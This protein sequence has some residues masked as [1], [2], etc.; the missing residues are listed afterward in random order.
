MGGFADW[1]ETIAEAK[2]ARDYRAKVNDAETVSM[3]QSLA[4]RPNYK[5]AYC[6]AVCPAGEDVI[7]AYRA[8]QERVSCRASSIRCRRKRKRSMSTRGSDAEDYVA[9]RFPHKRVKHVGMVLR[10]TSDRRLSERPAECLSAQQIRGLEGDLSFHLYRR[11][12]A[13]GD[14]R[15]RRPPAEDKTRALSARPTSP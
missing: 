5:A 9:R 7:G 3:W 11:D 4:Y 13:P 1:V 6:M 8:R 14:H 10:P 12:A 15:H 2:S